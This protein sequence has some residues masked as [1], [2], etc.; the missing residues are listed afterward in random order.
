MALHTR[1]KRPRGKGKKERGRKEIKF[2]LLLNPGFCEATLLGNAIFPQRGS[3]RRVGL[4][5]LTEA[6][7]R[8][9]RLFFSKRKKYKG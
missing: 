6:A 8:E 5:R 1:R 3:S 4:A 9:A 7:S 2:C